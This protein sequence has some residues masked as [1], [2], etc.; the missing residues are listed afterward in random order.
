[1]DIVDVIRNIK[2]QL[3]KK[4]GKNLEEMQNFYVYFYIFWIII[5]FQLKTNQNNIIIICDP[6]QF[7]FFNV[8]PKNLLK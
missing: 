8:K 3:D 4:E 7:S 6:P 1:M 5:N 2:L